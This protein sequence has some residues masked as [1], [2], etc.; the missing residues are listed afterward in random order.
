MIFLCEI[1]KMITGPKIFYQNQKKNNIKE[2]N[3]AEFVFS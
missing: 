3:A 1:R 2:A